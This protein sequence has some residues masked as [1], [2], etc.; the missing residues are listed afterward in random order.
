MAGAEPGTAHADPGAQP[1]PVQ[2]RHPTRRDVVHPGA[3]DLAAGE[4][5]EQL[6]ADRTAAAAAWHRPRP[7]YPDRAR[8]PRGVVTRALAGGQAPAW[9]GRTSRWQDWPAA[10]LAAR[11]RRLG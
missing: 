9:A 8:L 5:P 3:R 4:R 11:K 1:V 10:G 7:A 2:A 6:P